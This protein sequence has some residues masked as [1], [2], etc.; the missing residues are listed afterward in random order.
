[1]F[2][3]NS[4][5]LFVLTVLGGLQ[6]IWW[7]HKVERV[8]GESWNYVAKLEAKHHQPTLHIYSRRQ[9]EGDLPNRNKCINIRMYNKLF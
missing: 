3:H 4:P 8:S 1:M 7:L 2:Q 9:G 5:Y 6:L